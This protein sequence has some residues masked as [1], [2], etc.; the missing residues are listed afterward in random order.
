MLGTNSKRSLYYLGYLNT[1]SE[2][3]LLG[4]NLVF[5]NFKGILDMHRSHLRISVKRESTPEY[6]TKESAKE[7][8]IFKEGKVSLS[9]LN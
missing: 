5:W 2:I 4:I 9:Y 3:K 8:M 1:I 7:N 6:N